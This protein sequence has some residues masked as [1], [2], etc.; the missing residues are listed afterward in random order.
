VAFVGAGVIENSQI[1]QRLGYLRMP[2]G[3]QI[4]DSE[5]ASTRRR[6]WS[7]SAPGRRGAAGGAAADRD[8]RPPAREARPGR[9]GGVLGAGDPGN[10]KAIGRVMN[11][12]AE[13]RRRHRLRGDQARPRVRARQ[14]GRAEA[15][16]VAGQAALLRADTR[17]VP[18]ARA[19][20]P[21]R[22]MVSPAPRWCW[23]R[24]A[25]LI[26]IDDRGARVAEQGAGRAASS[27][28][29]RGSGEVGDEVLRDRGTWPATGLVVPVVAI[30][31][32]VGGSSRRRRRDYRGVRARRADRGAA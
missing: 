9:R 15:H 3:V 2:P 14:R 29:A 30:K 16:A 19:A 12:I 8:R 13:A 10:E 6:T 28:T 22:Q 17:G 20:R 32:A 4:R 31:P 24:T 27:S 26:R 25:D 11:H 1:A 23:P 5:I 7:A 21:G 18:P